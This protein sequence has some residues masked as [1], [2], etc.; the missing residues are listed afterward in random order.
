VAFFGD[1][2]RV[3][4]VPKSVG[5]IYGLLYASCEPLSFS[6]IVDRLE[7]SKGSASQGLQWLRSLGAIKAAGTRRQA[8]GGRHGAGCA[9]PGRCVAYEPE[10]GLRK[11]IGG[12]LRERLEPL[13]G[14]GKKRMKRLRELATLAPDDREKEFQLKRVE[15][16]EAW[17]RQAT[18]IIPVLKNLL[19]LRRR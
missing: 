13:I 4:D 5:Q 12:V 9:N 10:I 3:F 1:M 19:L 15:Q 18:L 7:I 14:Q 16:M 8:P 6:D 2:A 11:L 17:Q